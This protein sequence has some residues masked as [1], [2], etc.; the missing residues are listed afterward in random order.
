MPPTPT[1][2]AML[3]ATAAPIALQRLRASRIVSADRLAVPPRLMKSVLAA[4]RDVRRRRA[5]LLA[6]R[7]G[8]G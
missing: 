7:P 1:P 4:P 8:A 3:T 5:D 6:N 2:T